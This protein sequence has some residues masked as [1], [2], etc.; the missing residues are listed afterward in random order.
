[1]KRKL[2]QLSISC[3]L[4]L[5]AFQA[6]GG[7]GT[8]MGSGGYQRDCSKMADAKKKARCEEV[9]KTMNA[10]NGKAGDDLTNC[11]KERH[12]NNRK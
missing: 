3:V 6:F 4:G 2:M 8:A 1:M 5:F 10:C 7:E 9:N 11:M 12:R